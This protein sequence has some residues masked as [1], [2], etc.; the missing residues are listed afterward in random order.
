[1]A[2]QA[3]EH[4]PLVLNQLEKYRKD[5]K[6]L[7]LDGKSLELSDIARLTASRFEKLEISA[8]T[9]QILTENSAYLRQKI[10]SGHVVYG[11]NTGYG[12]SADV[13]SS[14]VVESQRALI[15]HLNVGFGEKL[16][17][18]V[19]RAAMAVRANSLSRGYSR[20]QTGSGRSTVRHGQRGCRSRR[21]VAWNGQRQWRSPSF[22]VRR[23]LHV[24]PRR[25]PGPASWS[26]DTVSHAF[27]EENLSFIEFQAKEALAVI[28]A[29]SCA[30]SL[31]GR[32]LFDTG[33]A[34]LLTQAV[35]AMSV[36]CMR[37]RTE[38]FHPTVHDCLY[39][40]GN[41]EVAA[42]LRSLLDESKLARHGLELNRPDEE[43][44]L[45]QDR[46]GLRTA[47]Q[48]L[49]PTVEVLRE[50]TRRVTVELNSSNDNP[51]VDHRNDEII[52][53]GNFQGI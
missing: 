9:R 13:R 1:M 12:G 4:L 28:N 47:P 41:Q 8:E 49:G 37:G 43:G 36:E 53:C 15:R 34:L 50:S 18:G 29:A 21:T 23:C 44:L 38:S 17:A 35:T 40:S 52:H 16:D 11:A 45:K 10:T 33:V 20:R 51:L 48:W 25:C 46:Y 32:V 22:V 5:G 6:I 26:S 39:H 31:A 27:K 3:V 30:A 14:D 24:R 42:N 19:V 2:S 7:N